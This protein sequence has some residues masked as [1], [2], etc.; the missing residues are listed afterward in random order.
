MRPAKA[1]S[2]DSGLDYLDMLLIHWPNPGQDKYVD[3]FAGLLALRESGLIKAAGTSN[4]KPAHIDRLVAETGQAPELNQIQLNPLTARVAAR[5]YHQTHSIVTEGWSP[6]GGGG[7][8]VLTEPVV[9]ELATKHNRSPAQVVLRWNVQLG[10]VA[11][12][13]SSDPARIAANLAVYDF[14]LSPDDMAA[15]SRLDQG[16]GVAYDSD[17]SGH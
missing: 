14:E 17:V 16:E 4:F 9:K 13:K 3:A 10:V 6:F 2:S 15:L 7:A 11:I 1:A 5:D 8:D 12:P